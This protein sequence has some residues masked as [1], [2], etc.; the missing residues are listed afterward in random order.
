MNCRLPIANCQLVFYCDFALEM[1]REF[2][3]SNW[4]S[5]IGNRKN[6]LLTPANF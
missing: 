5:A 2:R 4:Q 6:L 3:M 1:H